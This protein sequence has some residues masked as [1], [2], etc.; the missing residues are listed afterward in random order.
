MTGIETPVEVQGRSCLPLLRG[1][2]ETHREDVFSE[3]H[4]HGAQEER[5]FSV[6]TTTARI[7]CY[8]DRPYGELY[9]LTV[10]PDCLHNRWA[11][12]ACADLK[13]EM[14][15]RLLNRLMANIARPDTREAMW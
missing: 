8:Q 12:P 9:D 10:D 6:Q 1:E 5:M 11:D 2:A 3:F 15:V 13:C 7:T 14:Q 4:A